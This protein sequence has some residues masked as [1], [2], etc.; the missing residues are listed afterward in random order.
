MAVTGTTR[1]RLGAARRHVGSN[2]TP[3]A[4][5]DSA[6][7]RMS[8][9]RPCGRCFYSVSSSARVR[10]ALLASVDLPIPEN[11]VNITVRRMRYGKEQMTVLGF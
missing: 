9:Y 5:A 7:V 1:N 4:N 3:S 8:P 11:A 6:Y 2:P 10:I